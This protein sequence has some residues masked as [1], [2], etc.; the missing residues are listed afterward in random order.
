MLLSLFTALSLAAN[1]SIPHEHQGIIA[2][3]KGAPPTIPLTA[4]EL[5]TLASG[6]GIE[7][8]F[9]TSTGGRAVA[10]MDVNATTDTI[11]SKIL[12]FSSYP[13]WVEGV[14][15]CETYKTEGSNIYARFVLSLMGVSVEYYVKHT[16][17]RAAGYMTWTL[18]YSRQ[19]DLDDSVGFWRVTSLS[20]SPVRSRVEYSVDVRI[21]G[22]VPGFIADMIRSR[23]VTT[24]TSW[25]KKQSEG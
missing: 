15:L 16:L 20:T 8:Q 6:Q 17:N 1:P 19:S 9:E 10:V 4:A 5:A 24:A 21:K 11:W 2:P 18:D 14:S 12:A 23:G 13:R 7:K 3:Y 22:W 25:V